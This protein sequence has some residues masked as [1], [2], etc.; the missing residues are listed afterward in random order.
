MKIYPTDLFLMYQMNLKQ[1][2]NQSL[3]LMMKKKQ[4]LIL[5]IL[6]ADLLQMELM[7]QRVWIMNGTHLMLFIKVKVGKQYGRR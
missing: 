1:K 2:Q 7:N 5:E 4:Q 3:N 6:Q